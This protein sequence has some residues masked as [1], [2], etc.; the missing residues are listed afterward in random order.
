MII[1]QFSD[2]MA[3]LFVDRA[4]HLA[5][6]DVRQ[7]DVHVRR[8]NGRGN[9]LIP[10]GNRDDDIRAEVIEHGREFHQANAGGLGRADQVL[11]FQHHINLGIDVK[12]VC[13]DVTHHAS[14]AIQ[15]R[16]S[17]CHDLQFQVG[18]RLD[19]FERRAY[20]RIDWDVQ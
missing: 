12:A 10:I 1:G 8:G 4:G 17:G 11:P 9:R 13:L 2:G 15:Q 14:I 16:R 5:A 7:G 6:L 19:G 18:V 20:T 3:H